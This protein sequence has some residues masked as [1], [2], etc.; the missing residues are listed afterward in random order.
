VRMTRDPIT[1]FKE[2]I[3]SANLTTVDDLKVN[4]NIFYQN[5]SIFFNVYDKFIIVVFII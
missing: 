1:S 5:I 3:L 4:W 2:K